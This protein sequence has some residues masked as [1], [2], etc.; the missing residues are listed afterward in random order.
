MKVWRSRDHYL[1]E[2]DACGSRGRP[3]TVV[4]ETTVDPGAEVAQQAHLER[5]R[6]LRSEH[7]GELRVVMTQQRSGKITRQN[8]VAKI[9][10]IANKHSAG[11]RKLVEDTPRPGD[12]VVDKV[13]K[14]PWCGD[15]SPTVVEQLPE[16]ILEPDEWKARTT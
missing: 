5:A 11:L 2:C 9:K 6:K 3:A 7:A 14:C 10:E 8:A 13:A 4:V 15:E 16:G 12:G 1:A